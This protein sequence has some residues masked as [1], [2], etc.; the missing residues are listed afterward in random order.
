MHIKTDIIY[1]ML[2]NKCNLSCKYCL[3]RGYLTDSVPC[4]TVDKKV[5][6]FI[7]SESSVKRDKPMRI[8][9]FGGEPL[10]Y[11][12][13]I[14][15]MVSKT[16]HMNVHYGIITNGK[17]L[18]QEKLDYMNEYNFSISISWDGNR[19]SEVRGY[20]VIADKKDLI[21]SIEKLCITGVL[22]QYNYIN[23]FLNSLNELENEY[24]ERHNKLFGINADIIMDFD[25]EI[26]DSTHPKYVDLNKAYTQTIEA[27]NTYLK[28][29]DGVISPAYAHESW[30]NYK[31]NKL[32]NPYKD[33]SFSACGCGRSTVSMNLKGELFLCHNG[34][35]KIG[36]IESD[37][38]DVL[39]EIMKID[40]NRER[41]STRCKECEVKSFCGGACPRFSDKVLDNHYCSLQN[42][43]HVPIINMVESLQSQGC[44]NNK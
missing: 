19:S 1:I 5:Y 2:G 39:N 41:W 37:Y 25:G 22:S 20:D 43:I 28:S 11:W 12:E 14:K 44:E 29:L 8:L 21:L 26:Q 27:C 31:L 9:F 4:K 24:T 16:S 18:T 38:Y 30:I 3:Q 42:A 15:E 35:E 36:T 23:D 6:D 34:D 33:L 17:L 7:E 10:V 13:T 40:H 32:K